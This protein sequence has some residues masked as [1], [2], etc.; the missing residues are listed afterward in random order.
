MSDGV[1]SQNLTF[2][3]DLHT[4]TSNTLLENDNDIFLEEGE[5]KTFSLIASSAIDPSKFKNL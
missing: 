2:S 5:T 3:M 4:Q 1:T